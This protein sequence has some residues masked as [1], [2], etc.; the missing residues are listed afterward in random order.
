MPPDLTKYRAYVDHFDLTQDQKDDLIQT[1]YAMMQNRVACAF[2]RDSVQ[3][4]RNTPDVIDL[5]AAEVDDLATCC[6]PL[7]NQTER[8]AHE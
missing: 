7:P 4:A 2:G 1:L 5:I 6:D 8:N 3:L